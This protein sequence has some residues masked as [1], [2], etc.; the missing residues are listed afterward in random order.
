VLID[1]ELRGRLSSAQSKVFDVEP[2]HHTVE[3]RMQLLRSPPLDLDALPGQTK[4]V[5]CDLR[6]FPFVL[7]YYYRAF[8]KGLTLQ[9]CEKPSLPPGSVWPNQSGL[10]RWRAQ[11]ATSSRVVQTAQERSDV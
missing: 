1:G 9:E 5:R 8:H 2:G 11:R 6:R 7:G 4:F 10:A 3:I